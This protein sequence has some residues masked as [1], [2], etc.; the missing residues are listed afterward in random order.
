[1]LIRSTRRRCPSRSRAAT[2]TSAVKITLVVAGA[3]VIVAGVAGTSA[4]DGQG[5]YDDASGA[6]R[7]TLTTNGEEDD[8][9]ATHAER[10]MPMDDNL[11]SSFDSGGSMRPDDDGD[12]WGSVVDEPQDLYRASDE[13]VGVDADVPPEEQRW[14]KHYER[15]SRKWYYYDASTGTSQWEVPVGFVEEEE[16]EEPRIEPEEE[17]KHAFER[18]YEMR[19]SEREPEPEPVPEPEP[20]PEPAGNARTRTRANVGGQSQSRKCE[21]QNESQCRRRPSR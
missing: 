17:R 11:V 14:T 1:M 16:A 3:L 2:R 7:I 12:A 21:S 5:V 15:E 13:D 9:G 18:V 20:E 8:A 19:E 10:S 4:T 6:E